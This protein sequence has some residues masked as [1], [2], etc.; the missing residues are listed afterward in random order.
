MSG[1]GHPSL[2]AVR[3]PVMAFRGA[4]TYV[5]STDMYIELVAGARALGLAPSGAVDLRLKRGIDTQVEY[6]YDG[7]VEAADAAAAPVRFSFVAGA[8]TVHGRILATDRPVDGRKPYDERAIW[9]RARID[10][11]SAALQAPCGAAPIETV[12]ALGVLLHNSVFKP[13]EGRRWLLSRLSL[14]RPLEPVDSERMTVAMTH[15]IGRTMTRSSLDA[16]DGMLGSMDFILGAA[17]AAAAS[18]A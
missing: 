11:R 14:R 13:P 4:R 18:R 1:S 15:V 7:A 6:H 8:T 10:D 3:S 5:H 16:A 9:D 17:P 2:P 12:T